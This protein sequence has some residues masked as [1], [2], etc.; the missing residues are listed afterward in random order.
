[1]QENTRKHFGKMTD[2]FQQIC[3][4]FNIDNNLKSIKRL[5]SGHINETYLVTTT[6]ENKYVLQKLSSVAFKDVKSVIANKVIVSQHLEQQNVLTS[7]PYKVIHFI[8]THLNTFYYKENKDSYW[9]LMSFIPD[10]VTYDVAPNDKVVYEAGKLFGNFIAQTETLP[11]SNIK[12][13]LPEFHS[14]PFRFL[15]FEEALNNA[16]NTAKQK[17]K[18]AIEFAEKCKD[19]M[20]E[21]SKLRHLFPIRITHNDAKLSNILFNENGEGLAVIDLDTVMPGII[22]YDFGDSIRSICTNVA[23]DDDNF[24]AIAINLNY[25]KAFCK[26][27]SEFTFG[28]LNREEI[29]YLP[30]GAKTITFIMGLRIL[31]DYLNNNIYYKVDYPEHNLVRAKN[32][33][34]LVENI[35]LNYDILKEITYAAYDLENVSQ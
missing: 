7:L 1:M 9:N 8:K 5:N 6:L 22:A 32:Q 18:D 10:S 24:D 20:H 16:S 25:Y 33:F 30:L 29:K 15:Q 13:T 28:I 4:H 21:L 11:I 17:A 3:K 35:Q 2:Y 34:K 14:I 31:T 12:E 23:E 27:Y 19:E 26:G